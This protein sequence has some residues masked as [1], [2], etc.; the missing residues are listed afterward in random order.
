[1]RSHLKTATSLICCTR[2][3]YEQGLYESAKEKAELVLKV[4]PNCEEAMELVE[5]CKA[6]LLKPGL[7][8]TGF[9]TI[10]GNVYASIMVAG[11]KET[12]RVHEGEEF[13]DFKISAIDRDLGAVV[14]AWGIRRGRTLFVYSGL[15]ARTGG[16]RYALHLHANRKHGCAGLHRLR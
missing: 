15:P 13:G 1:M 5:N 4:D 2:Q 9:L 6:E 14:V 10:K 12:H 3:F 11:D 7:R 8:V 16:N